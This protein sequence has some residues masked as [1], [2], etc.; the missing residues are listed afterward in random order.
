[1]T[2]FAQLK[3]SND[4]LSRLLSQVEKVNSPQQS[5]NS[6]QDD[7]FWRPELDKSGNGYAVVRFLP[8]AEGNELPWVRVFNHGFQGPTGKWYIENSLTTLNQKDPVAEYNSILWNS[9]TEANK[10][11]ARKQKRRLSYIANVL[12]VSDPKHPEN[13]G[14]VK[15]FKFGKKIFDK[16]TDQM[17]P[18]FEDEVPVNPFDPWTGTNFKLKIRK[19]EGFTNYDKSEFDSKSALFEGDDAKIEALWKTQYNLSEFIAPSNFKSYDELKAK[20]DLVLN[21]NSAPETFAPSA[22]APV[23][24]EKAPWVEEAK[25]TTPAVETST[26]SDDEDDEAMSYFSKLAADE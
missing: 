18:Q 2:N 11:I 5:N 20:L 12:V 13:E 6:N 23:A 19:V 9:G 22:P 26:V 10:D 7:R 21:L 4:N 14:Q 1:M 17:K 15:L 3:K 24:E 25:S 16:I 8:E